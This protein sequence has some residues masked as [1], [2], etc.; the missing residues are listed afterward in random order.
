MENPFTFGNPVR[1]PGRFFGRKEEVRQVVNRLL[2]SAHESTSIVGERRIGKT[3]LLKYIAHPQVAPGLGLDP[4]RYCL[5]YIDFQGLTDITPQ[6]FWQRVLAKMKRA[7]CSDSLYPEIDRLL[8]MESF[9]LFDLEDLCEA[10]AAENLTT[11]LLL[12][13]FEY[14][15]Q[16]PNFGADFF[17]GLR[18]LAIHHN[19][20]LVTATRRELVDLCHSEELKGSPFFNIFAN[21]VLRPFHK[22]EVLAMA[23][24]YLDEIELPFTPQDHEEIYRLAGGYPFF[25]QIAGYYLVEAQASGLSGE[26]ALSKMARQKMAEQYQQQA[27]PHYSYMWS[28]CSESEKIALLAAL[29]LGRQNPAVKNTAS[30]KHSFKKSLPTLENLVKIYPHAQIDVPELLKRG[31]LYEDPVAAPY[32]AGMET[33]P[34]YRLLSES[35]ERWIG[36]EIAAGEGSQESPESVESWLQSGGK[37]V[38]EPVKGALPRFKKK[39]WPLVSTVLQEVSIELASSAAFELMLRAMV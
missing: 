35:L 32:W 13:E 22:E 2:S 21:V 27:D 29:S 26:K 36:Q 30:G 15:T 12:D 4:A 33:R 31:L 18:A 20:P 17:G 19:L 7:L 14:V 9:D 28:H 8:G 11:V 39:Y 23:A 34:T 25:V 6:R 10:I 38:V 5:I 3:S 37:E 16:N 1:D 24:A